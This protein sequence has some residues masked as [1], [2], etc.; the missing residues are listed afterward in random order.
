M[1]SSQA[2]RTAVG[3]AG[4]L[5]TVFQVVTNAKTIAEGLRKDKDEREGIKKA[6]DE[7]KKP[8]ALTEETVNTIVSQSGMSEINNLLP[9]L[10]KGEEGQRQFKEQLLILAR[11]YARNKFLWTIGFDT[12]VMSV[13]LAAL[14][15][16]WQSIEQAKNI[17][18]TDRD[19]KVPKL[20]KLM[21][22]LRLLHED[23]NAKLS[24]INI[25]DAD[26][27]Y[28]IMYQKSEI[29]YKIK[30]IQLQVARLEAEI[31]GHQVSIGQAMALNVGTGV[32]AVGAIA[33]SVYDYLYTP[34]GYA[35]VI[36]TGVIVLLG[37]TVIGNGYFYYLGYDQ[38]KRLKELDDTIQ[39]LN[40]KLE[41]LL[42]S[43][44]T[45]H[46][47]EILGVNLQL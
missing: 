40:E 27:I 28:R 26:A 19:E 14:Y 17:V 33:Y 20:R 1:M 46:P 47:N 21:V 15:V 22:A 29:K 9:F 5:F 42:Q 45:P 18:Q 13:E 2:A 36:L 24:V 11:T 44:E 25:N 32:V 31:N 10:E 38:L 30:D 6:C 8:D 41:E 35:K 23:L 39:D 43:V 12:L 16:L 7:C 37:L 34:L 4:V 3:I